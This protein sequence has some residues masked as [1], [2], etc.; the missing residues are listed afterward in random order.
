MMAYIITSLVTILII[1]FL[2][3]RYNFIKP[4]EE[5]SH[6]IKNLIGIICVALIVI[7]FLKSCNDQNE[8]PNDEQTIPS[9]E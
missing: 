8:K 7:Y 9:T 6:L 5:K 4:V 1:A 3:Y 2:I